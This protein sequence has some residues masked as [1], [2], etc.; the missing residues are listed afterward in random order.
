MNISF[1][2]KISFFYS[3]RSLFYVTETHQKRKKKTLG[4]QFLCQSYRTF[5]AQHCQNGF[6][7]GE[8]N[9]LRGIQ[10]EENIAE[11]TKRT[12]PWHVFGFLYLFS[13]L[14]TWVSLSVM[15]F[16]IL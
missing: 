6:I 12:I 15:A 11:S 10:T 14:S 8:W 4:I 13:A 2:Q 7:L 3:S 9:V 5:N 16:F 1:F